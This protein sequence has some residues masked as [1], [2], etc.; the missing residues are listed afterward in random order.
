MCE[1]ILRASLLLRTHLLTRAV[2]LA[3]GK[4][5]RKVFLSKGERE[6]EKEKGRKAT[7][8]LN[9]RRVLKLLPKRGGKKTP[10]KHDYKYHRNPCLRNLLHNHKSWE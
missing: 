5:Q 4:E 2:Q 6:G 8:R 7:L 9:T 1:H 10:K 3:G